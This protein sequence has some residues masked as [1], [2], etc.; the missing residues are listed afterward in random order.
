MTA[1]GP[2]LVDCHSTP[3]WSIQNH[4][5]EREGEKVKER[6]E[7]K[8]GERGRGRYTILWHVFLGLSKYKKHMISSMGLTS[9][10][11]LSL[12]SP[13][14]CISSAT[15]GGV[16][17]LIVTSGGSPNSRTMVVIVIGSPPEP[18]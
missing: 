14:I 18:T 17:W 9:T 5:R 4:S 7:S 10:S 6:E 16:A 15:E 13:A 11:T 8:G 1:V 2:R 3:D 12:I